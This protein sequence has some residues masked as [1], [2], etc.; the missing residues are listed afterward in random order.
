MASIGHEESGAARPARVRGWVADA[1]ATLGVAVSQR[2]LCEEAACRL[3]VSGVVL[4]VPVPASWPEPRQATDRLGLRLAELE[5]TVGEGPC[6][7]A[8]EKGGPVLAGDL[9]ALGCQHR[10]PA[11]A[12]LA[13]EAG[14]RGLFALPMCV[15]SVSLG[16][17]AL[18]RRAPGMLD[19]VA[20]RN[21]LAFA[22]LARDMLLD[23]QAGLPGT[24]DPELPP[25]SAPV[26][27]A[28]GM[29]AAR[30][31]LGMAEALAL[32]RARAFAGDRSLVDLAGDVVAGRLRSDLTGEPP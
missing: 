16:V 27:Q 21:A 6:L 31:N 14:A 7:A 18:Y 15:G 11:F 9:A 13:I 8:T 23:E 32:L 24:G 10:W 25:H 5:V 22:G 30:L 4:T 19:P 20:L 28:T 29:I 12:P 2:I 1:A 17:L 3:G 26:H